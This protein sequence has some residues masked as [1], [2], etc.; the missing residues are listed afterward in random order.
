VTRRQLYLRAIRE[1]DE[2]KQAAIA[3][4]NS[5]PEMTFADMQHTAVWCLL[6]SASDRLSKAMGAFHVVPEDQE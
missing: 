4:D 5:R 1:Y 2:A 3:Y 6:E